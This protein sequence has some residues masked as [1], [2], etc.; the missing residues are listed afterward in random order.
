MEI[1]SHYRRKEGRATEGS[2]YKANINIKLKLPN[3]LG[4][5]S[6][7]KLFIKP[8]GG[9]GPSQQ[10]IHGKHVMCYVARALTRRRCYNVGKAPDKEKVLCGKGPVQGEG[11][12][13]QGP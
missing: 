9:Q 6:D 13:W 8:K 5:G 4:Q 2:V 3:L 1:C 10:S 11:F 12:M 7:D